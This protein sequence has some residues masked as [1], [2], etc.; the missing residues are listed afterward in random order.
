VQPGQKVLINGGSGG[1][2]TFAVQIA[3]AFGAEV[4]AVCSTRNLELARSLG[5]DHVVDYTR[6]DVTMKGERFDVVLDNVGNFPVSG[7]NRV[8]KPGGVGVVIGFSG[9]LRLVKLMMLGPWVSRR[10]RQKIGTM[11]ARITKEDLTFLR[12]LLESGKVKPVIDR[13]FPLPDVAEA[14]RYFGRGHSQGKVI[15]TVGQ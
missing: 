4:T 14:L 6:E 3:K 2:G 5:A 7:Y 9:V 8:L 10:G 12:G 1:V 11:L 15:I 13:R